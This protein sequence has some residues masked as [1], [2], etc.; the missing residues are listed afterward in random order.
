MT[1]VTKKIQLRLMLRNIY[2]Y[3]YKIQP[4]LSTLKPLKKMTIMLRYKGLHTLQ[5]AH[6][7]LWCKGPYMIQALM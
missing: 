7:M 5:D 3:K 4:Q 6:T 2:C 1:T